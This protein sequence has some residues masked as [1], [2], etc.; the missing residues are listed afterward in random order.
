MS[1]FPDYLEAVIEYATSID[2]LKDVDGK[3]DPWLD[4]M[5]SSLCERI[6]RY[7]NDRV[8]ETSVEYLSKLGK[9]GAEF[10]DAVY[11][12][13]LLRDAVQAVID[14]GCEDRCQSQFSTPGPCTCHI[15][16][17]KAALEP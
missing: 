4:N 16:R 11:E 14:Q 7:A 2:W 3:R 15:G 17:L 9:L 12:L 6:E 5:K 8:N 10:S 1:Q 13:N